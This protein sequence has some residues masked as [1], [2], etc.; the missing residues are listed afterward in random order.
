[1][2]PAALIQIARSCDPVSKLTDQS[3][4]AFPVGTDGI[5]IA[6]IPFRPAD[7]KFSNLIPAFTQIPWLG[8]QLHLG[9]DWILVNDIE[10]SPEAIHFVQLSRQRCRQVEAEPIHMHL[11]NPVP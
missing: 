4:I 10:K 1:T 3:T 2:P 9:Q 8:N 7:R 5:A 11:K 6:I